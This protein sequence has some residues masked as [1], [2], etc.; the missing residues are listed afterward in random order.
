MAKLQG[1]IV[2]GMKAEEV[3]CSSMD[4]VEGSREPLLY[5]RIER[6]AVFVP[7]KHITGPA[8]VAL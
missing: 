1:V 6:Q 7:A 3:L 8:C 4:S 5:S 2:A